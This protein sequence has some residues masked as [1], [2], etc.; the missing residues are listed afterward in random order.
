MSE[1]ELTISRYFNKNRKDIWGFMGIYGKGSD[2]INPHKCQPGFI[3][4]QY[5]R[6]KS[7]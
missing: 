1:G 3:K 5:Y 6:I 2:D 7:P 4:N